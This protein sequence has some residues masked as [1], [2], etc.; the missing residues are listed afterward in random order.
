[1]RIFDPSAIIY[2]FITYILMYSSENLKKFEKIVKFE[3]V[4][5]QPLALSARSHLLLTTHSYELYNT[6]T[7]TLNNYFVADV[8]L[9][10]GI[11]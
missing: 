2:L 4:T 1:M 6:H 5:F 7:K 9:Q 3:S 10:H 11:I 8:V